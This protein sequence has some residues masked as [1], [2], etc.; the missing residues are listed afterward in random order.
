MRTKIIIILAVL[1]CSSFSGWAKLHVELQKVRDGYILEYEVPDYRAYPVNT[2][3]LRTSPGAGNE[4]FSQIRIPDF[5]NTEE[6]GRPE[7]PYIA[8][9]M[10]VSDL[11]D[12]PT[13]ELVE[14]VDKQISLEH[15]CFPAQ[16]PWPKSQPIEERPFSM[17]REYYQSQGEKPAFAVVADVF[18]IRN[19]PCVYVKIFPFSYNPLSKT[20]TVAK[21]FTL[22]IKTST[23][24][25]TG[26]NSHV[27]EQFLRHVLVNFNDMVEPV[28]HREKD[29]YHIITAPQ[30]EDE[31]ADFVSFRQIRFN[32][33][34]VTTATTGTSTSAIESYIDALNPTPSFM[35]LVGDVDDIP[36]K[37][38]PATDVY[39]ASTDNDVHADMML[40]RFSVA[41]VTD[42]SNII[43]KTIYMEENLAK[44]DKKA[45]FIGGTDS[46]SGHIAEGTHNYVIST[47]LEPDGYDC[48]KLYTNS[49]NSASESKQTNAVNEGVIFDFYS[50][51]GSNTSWAV[52]PWSV[53]E[54]D[55]NGYTNKIYPFTAA[56]ACYTGSYNG[57]CVAESWIRAENGAVANI[58]SSTTSYWGGDDDFERG[59][60]DAFYDSNNPI[61][62]FGGGM[63]A[64]KLNQS[65][66]AY[67]KQYN[68]FGDPGLEVF[69]VDLAP[70]ITVTSPNGGEDWEQDRTFAVTWEDNIDDNVRIELLKGTSVDT[71][72][73]ASVPSEGLFEWSIPADFP[74]GDDY[75]IRITCVTQDTLVDESD[76]AFTIEEKSN[77]ELKT[78]NGGE[79][80]E[81]E[82]DVEITWEDNLSGNVQ[83]DLVRDTVVYRNIAASVPSNGSY[84]W[85]IPEDVISGVDYKIRVTSLDKGWLY[86]ESDGRISIQNPMIT[87]F[88]YVQDFD[89]MDTGSTRPLSEYWEQLDD[90][91]FDWIVLSGPTPSQQYESTGPT[92][93]HTSGNGNYVYVEAS[94]PNNPNKKANMLTPVFDFSMLR[95]P[96]LTFWVQMKSDSNTMGDIYLDIWSDGSW[97]TEV[98]HLTDDHGD[99]WFVNTVDLSEYEGKRT[100]IKFRG[101]TGASWCGDM[102][103]DDFEIKGEVNNLPEFSS[104]PDTT[105]ESGK[106][107]LYT[108]EAKDDD[109]DDLTFAGKKLPSWLTLTDNGDG[110]AELKGTPENGDVGENEVVITVS[111]G[112]IAEPVE[113][114][115][116][117]N[118]KIITAVTTVTENKNDERFVVWPN[119]V[120]QNVEVMNFKFCD[121]NIRV[122]ELTVYDAVGNEVYA[123]EL[124]D[125]KAKWDLPSLNRIDNAGYLAVLWVTYKD[126]T[127]EQLQRIIGVRE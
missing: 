84:T 86:D 98:V 73:A 67:H 17:D 42:L 4:I 48:L 51:H 69:P 27:F 9:Y 53:T 63:N 1:L 41:D 46:G 12:I 65:G 57:N 94:N 82:S 64:G 29:D 30:Y 75:K 38:S 20:L 21:K 99:P 97:D 16:I 70:Y 106:E 43:R 92:G 14:S 61:T 110:T 11:K 44:F 32:V 8:F 127:I 28:R 89:D 91:D 13:F 72:L 76:S 90:D 120:N 10:A 52:G 54:S 35:L 2:L 116:T 59:M 33:E 56:F 112:I 39:Y 119:P 104:S 96:V 60:F 85:T 6:I 95:E 78:P 74:L 93:D 81:K 103:I 24:K 114:A 83:L 34:M 118:V 71:L 5:K 7:L 26:L 117:I 15:D 113:Q 49:D 22:K 58:G 37:G 45:V 111:D 50:G 107:Y 105:A 80:L 115:F 102:C 126:G 123:A 77:L 79:Y 31:L 19:V 36:S 108:V 100:Q 122:A 88:P 62:S 25:V 68:L 55:I 66:D 125:G 18:D 109:G 23:N 101:I 124:K 87:Q 40:G 3:G 47:Y 121:D